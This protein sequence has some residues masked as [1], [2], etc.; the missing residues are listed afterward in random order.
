MAPVVVIVVFTGE[1]ET[2]HSELSS[3]KKTHCTLLCLNFHFS[4]SPKYLNTLED[5]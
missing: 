4:A 3:V 1:G 5:F 2:N